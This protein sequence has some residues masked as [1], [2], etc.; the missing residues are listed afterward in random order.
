MID[1]I[2]KNNLYELN[3]KENYIHLKNYINIIDIYPNRITILV[4]N[5][6]IIIEGEDLIIC[7]LDEYELLI[8]G[9]IKEISFNG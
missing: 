8:R 7:C 3:I 5:N 4:K 1:K 6:K 9:T 2:I